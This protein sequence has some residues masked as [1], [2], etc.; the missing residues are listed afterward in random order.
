MTTSTANPEGLRARISRFFFQEEVPYTLALL[1]ITLPMVLLVPVLQRW[2]HMRELYSTDGAPTPLWI[3][4][5][6]KEF[7]PIPSATLAIA[8]Y[9]ILIWSLISAMI[10]WKTRLSLAIATALYLLFT[11]L[12]TISTMTKYTV[13]ASHVLLLLSVSGCGLVW[14]VDAWLKGQS[15]AANWPGPP[16]R[17]TAPVWPRRLIAILLGVVY[18]GAAMTKMHTQ[19]YFSGDQ[20]AYW[21]LTNLNMAN[22]LGERLS[23]HPASLVVS[24]YLVIVWEITFIVACWKGWGRTLWIGFGYVFHLLTALLLG[25]II[26]PILYVVLYLA[27]FGEDDMQWLGQKLRRL[28]RRFPRVAWMGR[29]PFSPRSAA[30]HRLT[31]GQQWATYGA[32]AG[33]IAILNLQ[34]E[35]QADVYGLRRA[36]GPYELQPIDPE[37]LSRMLQEPGGL[38]PVDKMFAFDIGTE[39]LGEV[40]MDRRKSFQQ[41]EQ[42]IVQCNLQPQHEDLYVEVQIRDETD[43]ILQRGGLVIARENL[44]GNLFYTLDKSLDPGE[45]AFVM[46]IDGQEVARKHIVLEPSAG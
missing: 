18:L 42:A 23:L 36:E 28:G 38:E 26:F 39:L 20:M 30:A 4:Y 40:L 21:L 12:D 16:P 37:R 6:H 17:P 34:A 19:G 27:L 25:L 13:I 10:G 7:L 44:R 3:N 14:S 32:V 31:G 22:P 1:R 5:G 24:A 15:R 33:L 41:G 46:R 9:G 11:L 35:R 8:L 29:D 43:R 2:P 45:Y